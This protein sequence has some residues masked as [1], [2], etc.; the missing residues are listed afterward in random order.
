LNLGGMPALII[1]NSNAYFPQSLRRVPAEALSLSL[2]CSLQIGCAAY[3]TAY[4]VGAGGFSSR[5]KEA[6]GMEV[7]TYLQL[8]PRLSRAIRLLPLYA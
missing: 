7:T 2:L 3:F 8:V 4:S 1:G 6:K 5:S